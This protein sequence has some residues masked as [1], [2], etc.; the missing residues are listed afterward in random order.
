MPDPR[1]SG[2]TFSNAAS[3]AFRINAERFS[4]P[5]MARNKDGSALNVT[6]S[7]LPGAAIGFLDTHAR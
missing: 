5:R 4:M 7:A 6:I 1:H 3:T 2:H